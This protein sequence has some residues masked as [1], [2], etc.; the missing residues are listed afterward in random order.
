MVVHCKTKLQV[1]GGTIQY[2]LTS[3]FDIELLDFKYFTHAETLEAPDFQ[4]L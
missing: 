4:F 2:N 1:N 3:K